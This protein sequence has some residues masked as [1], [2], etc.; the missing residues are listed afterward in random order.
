MRKVKVA[1][2]RFA[3]NYAC[4]RNSAPAASKKKNMS[5]AGYI[6]R[7]SPKLETWPAKTAGSGGEQS[8]YLV[9]RLDADDRRHRNVAVFFRSSANFV[10]RSEITRG[11]RH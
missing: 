2:R 6:T 11:K 10:K 1:A 9:G 3:E 4:A 5:F 7:T 8:V